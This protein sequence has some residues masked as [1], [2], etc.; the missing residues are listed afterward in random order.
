MGFFRADNRSFL[1]VKNSDVTS[2][3][4]SKAARQEEP[5]RARPAELLQSRSSAISME[6]Q[7]SS[8]ELSVLKKI[9][10]IRYDNRTQENTLKILS[11]PEKKVMQRLLSSSTVVQ[12]KGKDGKDHYSI[13]K[14][15]YDRFLMRKKPVSKE[16]PHNFIV[17]KVTKEPE[18]ENVAEL[19]SKGIIVLQTEAEASKVSLLL[20]QSIRHGQV[21]GTRSFSKNREF[22]ILLRSYF[23]RYAQSI[24]KK[25]RERSYRVS[26]IAKELNI[27]EDGARGI[28]CILAE[29]G[30]VMEKKREVFQIA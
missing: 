23:D 29:N 19:Q 6:Y 10:T 18:D 27:S 5:A 3:L 12:F 16:E 15:I 30:D 11:E 21:L 9:D 24:L 7:P 2:M 8:E 25:L 17:P 26:D 22:Y 13:P 20:E 4:Q 28:L 14:S 1:F